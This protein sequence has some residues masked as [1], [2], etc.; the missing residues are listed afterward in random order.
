MAT[1]TLHMYMAQNHTARMLYII[2]DMLSVR[3]SNAR[4]SNVTAGAARANGVL[5]RQ[6]RERI[7]ERV[8]ELAGCHKARRVIYSS[9]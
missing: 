5:A 8:Q 6:I 1:D 9:N 4:N 2:S 7:V 3:V